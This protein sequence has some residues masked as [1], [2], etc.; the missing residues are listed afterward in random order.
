[1]AI[2]CP[3]CQHKNSNDSLYCS[4]CAAPLKFIEGGDTTKTLITPRESLQEGSN[5]GGR[6]TI[7]EELGRG[8][9]GV[10]Y[11]AEDTKL[12]RAV[13]LKFLPPE[14]THIPEIHER[15]M[16][17]AQAAAGLDHPNICTVYEFDQADKTS[18]ISMAYIEGQSLKT[19]LESGPL[20][21]EETL[22]IAEQ[23]AEGLKEAHK[24]G[25][26][27][28]DIKCG[29]IMVTEKGQTKIMDFGL[30]RTADR[31]LLTKEG[32]TMGTV[33]YMS[34]EQTQGEKVDH[35]TDIWSFGAVLYEMLTGNLPFKGEHEQAVVHSIQKEKPEPISNLRPE[36][37]T[38]IEQVV[39]KAL[40][41]GPDK[42]YQ[43]IDE[44]IDDLK[45]ISV[46]IIPE[47]IKARIK[48]EKLS[49]RKKAFLYGGAAGLVTAAF[50]MVFLFFTGP[51]EAID[52][53]AVLPLENLT[54]DTEQQYF[55]DGITDELI[56]QLG[57]IS[58]LQ[59]VISRTSV[60]RYKN[61]DKSL[62]EIAREL[63][64]DA[65]VEGTVYHIGD[66]VRIKLQLFDAL[67]EERN[68]W[69]KRYDRPVTDVL[70]MY[71]E[72]TG[73]IADCIKIKLTAD[74]TKRFA[75]ARQV[76]P[77]VYDAYL[78]AR[79]YWYE[80]RESLYKG[81]EILNSTV[82]KNPDWAPLYA[83]IA[84]TWIWI[85]QGGFE[86]T[87]VTAPKIYENLNKAMELDPDLS[88]AHR[89]SGMIAQLMEWNW[90]KS[91]KAS[92]K[93]LA[94]NPN[95]SL[96]RM[97]YAQLLLIL[98]RS[99]EA[100]AQRELAMSLDPLNPMMKFMN[101]G[102]LVQAGDYETSLSLA[103]ELAA[104]DPKNFHINGLIE[105]IAYRLKEYDKVIEAVR[106]ALPFPMEEETFEEIERI[107]RESGIVSAYEEIMKHLEK[108][109]EDNYVS[110][111][112]MALRYIM[113]N[114]PDK[115]MDWVEKGF[116][117]HDP[118]MTYIATPARYFDRLFGNPRFIA[119]CKKM[120]LPLPK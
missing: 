119:I 112:D 62:P 106:Y 72:I 57:Q 54:G 78:K 37:P 21:L 24:K 8:G 9:M 118:L 81:L 41:K 95:D 53:I 108:F 45:S 2:T 73:A 12:K 23:V 38:S 55:V 18:F 105:L 59:R 29:N 61:T 77:E 85:Q 98:H 111:Q 19:K 120:N 28:R 82:D 115:A 100:L 67:P 110:F 97:F 56:G 101:L 33:A 17:E 15:F 104:D 65:L 88:E 49:K 30:A 4:K 50:V 5:V 31:T 86:P 26:V 99:D 48:K 32:S 116:E 103:E 92:L 84:E 74:E 52:S 71:G 36:V 6:Y 43:K 76:N 94:I 83:G 68:L 66:N 87:S 16:R 89:L 90:E 58:G 13:A 114:Q 27:H 70:M 93:A 60:M 64:V 63:N 69:T 102:T 51:A 34:P 7:V 96:S 10:V 11:K 22:G 107:Y 91:E 3:N 109:A 47:E 35:R 14:L 1:M 25:I 80:G 46:G 40:E 79:S 75:G 117:M 39:S 44:I 20:E 113:A 42:R